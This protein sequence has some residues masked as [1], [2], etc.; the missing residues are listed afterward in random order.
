MVL[1]CVSYLFLGRSTR[2]LCRLDTKADRARQLCFEQLSSSEL[3]ASSLERLGK[4]EARR[5]VP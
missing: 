3:W 1:V 2:L 5:G 4:G